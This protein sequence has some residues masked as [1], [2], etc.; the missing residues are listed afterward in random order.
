MATS[1][2]KALAPSPDQRGEP[3]AIPFIRW[4]PPTQKVPAEHLAAIAAALWQTTTPPS[5]LSPWE[6]SGFLNARERSPR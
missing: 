3:E 5:P 6:L 4:Y 1:H 2:S